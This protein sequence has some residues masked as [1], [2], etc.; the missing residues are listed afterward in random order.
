MQA[1]VQIA[2]EM[3]A[4]LMAR[5]NYISNFKVKIMPIS[6]LTSIGRLTTKFTIGKF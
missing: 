5:P 1:N 2:D 6:Y 3:Y 4:E